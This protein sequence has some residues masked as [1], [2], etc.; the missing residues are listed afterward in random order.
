MNIKIILL[1]QNSFTKKYLSISWMIKQMNEIYACYIQNI[2]V[3][4]LTSEMKI[5]E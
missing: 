2:F 4:K 1:K 3:Q 5:R